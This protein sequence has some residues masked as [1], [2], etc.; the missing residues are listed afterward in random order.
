MR[1]VHL[2]RRTKTYTTL[3]KGVKGA[4]KCLLQEFA[5]LKEST[6]LTWSNLFMMVSCFA[7]KHLEL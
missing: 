4:H 3:L 2:F 5:A 6:D 1:N 7:L